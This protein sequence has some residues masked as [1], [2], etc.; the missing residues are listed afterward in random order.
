MLRHKLCEPGL[1]DELEGRIQSRIEARRRIILYFVERVDIVDRKVVRVHYKVPFDYNGIKLLTD[2]VTGLVEGAAAEHT[3]SGEDA[4]AMAEVHMRQAT[5]SHLPCR[6]NSRSRGLCLPQ[7]RE[8]PP[9]GYTAPMDVSVLSITSR[10]MLEALERRGVP[11]DTLLAEAGLQRADLADPDARISAAAADRLWQAAYQHSADPALA[12]HIATALPAGTYR[13]FH[14]LAAHSHTVG[15][16]LSQIADCFAVI[17]PRVVL[18]VVEGDDVALEMH[19]PALGAVPR[20]PAEYTLTALL[21]QTRH[22]SAVDFSPV[23]AD[24]SFD[25]PEDALE[26]RR[27][28]KRVRYG[29]PVTALRF[30]TETWAQ[31]IPAADP[32]LGAML[33]AHARQV[34]Q[35]VPTLSPLRTR[36]ASL[37][38]ERL[39][40][41]PTQAACARKLGMSGRTLQR[42]LVAEG[43]S[44]SAELDRVRES[45]ARILL[46]DRSLSLSEIGWMLGFSDQSAFSRAFRRWA[47]GPPSSFRQPPERR[48]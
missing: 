14:Y 31:R 38:A 23:G 33:S 47:G 13:I 32:V 2:E 28:F 39:R 19:I 46:L 18:R 8:L 37:I 44:F 40:P 24:F 29:Q 9:T 34:T 35:S 15:D 4:A 3:A 6:Q 5:G 21:C 7:F 1:V 11:G 36:L 25:E 30:S 12:L 48:P 42:R 16:A 22:S 45:R 17:D 20:P 10:A 27:V 26:H 43:S 41:L